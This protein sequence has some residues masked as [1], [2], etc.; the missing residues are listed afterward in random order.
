MKSYTHKIQKLHK[1]MNECILDVEFHVL[2]V[3]NYYHYA[4]YN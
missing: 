2:V 3:P 4:R 1:L